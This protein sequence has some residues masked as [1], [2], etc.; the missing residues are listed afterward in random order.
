MRTRTYAVLTPGYRVLVWRAVLS[1]RMPWW[2]RLY[3]F[4]VRA[5][6]P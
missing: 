2:M 1:P 6:E 3:L 4:F 5:F